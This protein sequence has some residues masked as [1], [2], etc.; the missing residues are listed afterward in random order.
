MFAKTLKAARL[1]AGYRSAQKFAGVLGIEPATY[2]TYE[3]LNKTS[4]PNFETLTRICALL[5]ITPNDLLPEAAKQAPQTPRHP[6]GDS[7]SYNRKGLTM[8]V[9]KIY[10]GSVNERWR[11]E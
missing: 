9:N 1:R 4:E 7:Q 6:S 8:T 5:N 3:R 10:V 2:R 11:E